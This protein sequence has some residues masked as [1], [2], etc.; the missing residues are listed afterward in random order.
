MRICDVEG[1]NE[2]HS[3]KGLCKK[4]YDKAMFK[5]K[6]KTDKEFRER[7]K[8]TTAKWVK[9]NPEKVREYQRGKYKNLTREQK[10][11]RNR[12]RMERY[13]SDE[14]YR[15]KER[16]KGRASS[17]KYY[18]KKTEEDPNW[19]KQRQKEFRRKYPD[20]FNFIMCRYYFRKLTDE[21]RKILIKEVKEYG[22]S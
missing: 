20:K 2:K 16:A 1:C 9:K 6:Y 5:R 22:K 11:E 19:N 13:W 3:A 14:K 17:L 12:K 8:E 18:Y 15:E 10:D 4:H 7:M 21:Q